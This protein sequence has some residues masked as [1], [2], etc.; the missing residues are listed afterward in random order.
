[1]K[2]WGA[3]RRRRSPALKSL[4]RWRAVD[5]FVLRFIAGRDE[6]AR[7]GLA[8]HARRSEI[9]DVSSNFS[10][11]EI[12]GSLQR[13]RSAGRVVRVGNRWRQAR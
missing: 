1:M 4:Q 6:G 9:A 7:R 3:G 11:T 5:A 13:L 10:E 12:A 2:S 8:D